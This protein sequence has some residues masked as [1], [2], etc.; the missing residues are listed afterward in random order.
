MTLVIPAE[1]ENS[2]PVYEHLSLQGVSSLDIRARAE[3][4][5]GEADLTKASTSSVV[6]ANHRPTEPRNP[7]ADLERLKTEDLTEAV[8]NS[9]QIIL[10]KR[11]QR[12]FD[13]AF[14]NR[15]Q[16]RKASCAGIAEAKALP[17]F[18]RMI[19][20]ARLVVESRL[21]ADRAD[22]QI[23]EAPVKTVRA[24]HERWPWLRAH[25]AGERDIHDDYVPTSIGSRRAHPP[26]LPKPG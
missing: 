14:L 17:M 5:F 13:E 20:A 1:D 19:A 18:Q 3:G 11:R 25:M 12:A 4:T 7:N 16:I 9:G 6:L 26:R 15:H 2:L 8:L 22:N 21:A 10:V 23:G 24:E